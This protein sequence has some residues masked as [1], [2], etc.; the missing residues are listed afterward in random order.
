MLPAWALGW[1][2]ADLALVYVRQAGTFADLSMN[3]PNI[4]VIV[5]DA[6]GLS[7]PIFTQAGFVA[8]AAAGV[9]LI[10]GLQREA[11]ADARGS[12]SLR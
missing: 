6:P 3:A 2:A 5:Q 8:A 9:V 1:P 11:D 12:S 7:A 4:W 10:V